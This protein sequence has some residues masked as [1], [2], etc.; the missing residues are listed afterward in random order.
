MLPEKENFKFLNS[1]VFLER[2]MLLMILS[3]VYLFTVVAVCLFL[4][5][6]PPRHHARFLHQTI[7][8]DVL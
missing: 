5:G 6:F 3:L 7:A 1:R 4:L 2:H 8:D